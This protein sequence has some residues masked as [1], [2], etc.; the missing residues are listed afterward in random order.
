MRIIKEGKQLLSVNLGIYE[1]RHPPT[2]NNTHAHYIIL[3]YST[4][5]SE[6]LFEQK[7]TLIDPKLS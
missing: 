3:G 2:P 1:H 6:G 5:A 7:R 4:I